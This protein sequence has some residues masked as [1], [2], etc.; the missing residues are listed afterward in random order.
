M[1]G[2]CS[3]RNV[4]TVRSLGADHVVDYTDED[5]TRSAQSFDV[6]V[7]IAG[8]H[9]GRSASAYSLKTAR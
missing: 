3:T 5:F 7:D 4:E 1:T 8:N 9:R 6:L 2:V